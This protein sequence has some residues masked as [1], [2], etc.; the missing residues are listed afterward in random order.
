MFLYIRAAY[1]SFVLINSLY[2]ANLLITHGYFVQIFNEFGCFIVEKIFVKNW[3][4]FLGDTGYIYQQLGLSYN[5]Q[6]LPCDCY[7]DTVS[8]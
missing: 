5:R 4:P 2:F 8:I 7:K 3:L 1:L 6:M